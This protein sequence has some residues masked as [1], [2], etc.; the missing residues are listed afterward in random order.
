MK[1][2]HLKNK[3]KI[4]KVRIQ[5]QPPPLITFCPPKW[6]KG[7]YKKKGTSIQVEIHARS[8]RHGEPSP[9]ETKNKSSK[10]HSV[11]HTCHLTALSPFPKSN[12][13]TRTPGA[14]INKCILSLLP[15]GWA[16]MSHKTLSLRE[17]R[18]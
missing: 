3:C 12:W 8:Q 14:G 16:S 11:Q 15:G 1:V 6:S 2:Q 9:R 18:G 7:T 4:I 5:T 13:T 17:K 10:H